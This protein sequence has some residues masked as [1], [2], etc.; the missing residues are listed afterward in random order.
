MNVSVYLAFFFYKGLHTNKSNKPYVLH[1]KASKSMRPNG[2]AHIEII[3]KTIAGHSKPEF[4]HNGIEAIRV[5]AVI[6]K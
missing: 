2:G 5:K 6:M 1:M 3:N 4:P